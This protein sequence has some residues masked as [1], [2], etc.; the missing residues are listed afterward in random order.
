MTCFFS[1]PWMYKVMVNHHFSPPFGDNM[2]SIFSSHRTLSKSKHLVNLPSFQWIAELRIAMDEDVSPWDLAV[3]MTWR[4]FEWPHVFLIDRISILESSLLNPSLPH[5]TYI[6][7][8]K[9]EKKHPVTPFVEEVFEWTLVN[10]SC[11]SAPKH[12]PSQCIM[13]GISGCLGIHRPPWK[14][15]DSYW[16]AFNF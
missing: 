8:E 15:R 9:Y 4:C 14:R 2:I 11:G 7:T 6:A 12:R 3:W 10:I 13:G 16:K 5:K 1:D